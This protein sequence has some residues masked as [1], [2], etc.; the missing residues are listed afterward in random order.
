MINVQNITVSGAQVWKKQILTQSKDMFA[1]S[2]TL[3][4]HVYDKSSFQLLKLLTFSDQNI[5]AI[6][7]EPNSDKV[8]TDGNMIAQA[9]IDKKFLIWDLEHEMVKFQMQLLSHVTQIEWS[10]LDPNCI[11]VIQSNLEFKMIDL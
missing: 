6:A 3:A 10:P 4:I 1:F 8:Q 5:T 9:T 11:F 7:W 2:S